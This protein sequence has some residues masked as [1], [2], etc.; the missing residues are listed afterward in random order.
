[1]FCPKCGYS[2]NEKSFCGRCGCNLQARKN[3]ESI[4][5]SKIDELAFETTKH[6]VQKSIFIDKDIYKMKENTSMEI[7][8]YILA[9]IC[10]VCLF[11]N[12]IYWGV[13]SFKL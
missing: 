1:M 13:S 6:N 2:Y 7:L 5:E 9:A 3:V 12:F 11:G 10:L 8:V 4:L